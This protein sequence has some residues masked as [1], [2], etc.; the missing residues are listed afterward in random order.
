[1]SIASLRW[2]RSKR[3]LPSFAPGA[4]R[5][6]GAGR[7]RVRPRPGASAAGLDARSKRL[8]SPPSATWQAT[9]VRERRGYYSFELLPTAAGVRREAG[10]A[11]PA[12]RAQR[13]G[14]GGAGQPLRRHAAARFAAGSERFAGLRR[15]LELLADDGCAGPDRRLCPPSD[16][17]CRGA[18]DRAADVPR[19][20]GVV[21]V[22]AA[23]GLANR[24][25]CWTN[26]PEPAQCG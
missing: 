20:A 15:R 3:P 1:M 6:T 12:Q 10:G 25:G 17:D 4:R 9:A 16:R 24:H 26:L 11:G 22:S 13:P 19:P 7:G 21:R 5:G 23:P 18:G 2:P 8:A 14:R